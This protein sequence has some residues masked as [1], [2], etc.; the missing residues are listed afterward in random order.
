MRCCIFTIFLVCT[1]RIV[2][3]QDLLPQSAGHFATAG[4]LPSY[5]TLDPLAYNPALITNDT[6]ASS[7]AAFNLIMQTGG[8]ESS[9]TVSAGYVAAFREAGIVAAVS[10]ARIGYESLFNDITGCLT[11]GRKFDLISNRAAF[12][13]IRL[14]YEEIQFGGGYEP[15]KYLRTDAGLAMTFSEEVILSLSVHNMAAGE[16]SS[17]D[18]SS[19][20]PK[21]SFQIGA[22]YEPN[23]IPL[24][25]SMLLDKRE[26]TPLDASI[27]FH[28]RVWHYLSI[29]SGITSDLRKVGFGAEVFYESFT[30]GAGLVSY[31]ETGSSLMFSIG[32]VW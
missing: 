17:S 11:I 9:T 1:A 6:N 14:R 16:I 5:S 32:A 3:G 4:A 10:L 19:N 15:I 13:G 30:A 7:A 8:L 31:K 28:Y 26:A 24:T 22:A 12:A 20:A 18:G 25:V 21:R 23:V 29:M 27:G 2:H